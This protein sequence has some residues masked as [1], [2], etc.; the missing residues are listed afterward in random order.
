MNRKSRM[1]CN[2]NGPVETKVLP[3]VTG[4][5]VSLHCYVW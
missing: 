4:S 3:K 1:A 2:F 5:Q